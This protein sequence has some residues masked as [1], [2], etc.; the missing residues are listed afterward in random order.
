MTQTHLTI[1]AFCIFDHPNWKAALGG[2]F[3]DRID[4]GRLVTLQ[5]PWQQEG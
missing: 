3:I 4:T 2:E 5:N 1:E